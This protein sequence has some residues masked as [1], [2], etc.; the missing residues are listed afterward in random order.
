M[1][2]TRSREDSQVSRG[3]KESGGFPG[4][5]GGF[6]NVVSVP[7][8]LLLAVFSFRQI[9]F[10]RLS[11]LFDCRFPFSDCSLLLDVISVYTS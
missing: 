11:P 8:R 2:G 7:V 4:Q 6:V 1:G 9:F 10:H 3:D 5:S